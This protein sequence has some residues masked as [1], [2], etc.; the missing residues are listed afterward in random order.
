MLMGLALSK[1]SSNEFSDPESCLIV[2]LLVA[3]CDI[4][5]TKTHSARKVIKKLERMLIEKM[6]SENMMPTEGV[7]EQ[8]SAFAI[9]YPTKTPL[10]LQC[11]GKR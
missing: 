2:C 9:L 5:S 10:A 3:E 6:P 7:I 8:N 1:P 4:S 11:T